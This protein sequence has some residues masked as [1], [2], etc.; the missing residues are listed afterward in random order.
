[1][2]SGPPASRSG[3]SRRPAS[4]PRVSARAARRRARSVDQHEH[5]RDR[6]AG[7]QSPT[8]AP[9]CRAVE[10]ARRRAVLP[11]AIAMLNEMVSQADA[12]SRRRSE[13]D[14]SIRAWISD[15]RPPKKMPHAIAAREVAGIEPAPNTASA[16]DAHDHAGEHHEHRGAR[17]AVADDARGDEADRARGA[18]DAASTTLTASAGERADLGQPRH[19]VGA[20][21]VLPGD[22]ERDGEADDHDR[23][24]GAVLPRR[25]QD[26]AGRE[27]HQVLHGRQEQH[28]QRRNTSTIP[29]TAANASRQ[30]SA[31][32]SAVPSGT[33]KMKAAVPPAAVTE[34]ARA[35]CVARH[36]PRRVRRRSPTRTARAPRR[37]ARATATSTS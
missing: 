11:P 1:M 4:P 15:G 12:V 30:P 8:A 18:V 25:D 22:Q 34:I 37:P 10:H 21:G 31:W 19:D 36:Q 23:R 13:A 28:D 3:S 20:E 6:D 17:P 35:S 5:Q 16:D 9:R 32:P 27:R 26:L 14:C 2:R 33:P 29:P 24:D 7:D